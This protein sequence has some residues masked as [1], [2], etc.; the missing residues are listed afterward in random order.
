MSYVKKNTHNFRGSWLGPA[1]TKTTGYCFVWVVKLFLFVCV[2][3][4]ISAQNFLSS[5]LFW[6]SPEL[7]FCVFSLEAW[8]S[9]I[10]RLSETWFLFFRFFFILRL[11]FMF[12]WRQHLQIFADGADGA[13]NWMDWW[14]SGEGVSIYINILYKLIQT[15]QE[16]G[17]IHVF[18]ESLQS[19]CLRWICRE[20]AKWLQLVKRMPRYCEGDTMLKHSHK[21]KLQELGRR[22]CATASRLI[23]KDVSTFCNCSISIISW[24]Q[25]VAQICIKYKYDRIAY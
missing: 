20:T 19:S 14:S 24:S 21:I 13:N 9:K 23:F 8:P 11:W 22:S 25:A 10:S 12:E 3:L 17:N 7:L 18:A 5:W 15:T 16:I 6:F 2:S 4:L 1:L